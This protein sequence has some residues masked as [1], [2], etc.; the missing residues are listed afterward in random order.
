MVLFDNS[1]AFKEVSEETKAL[2]RSTEGLARLKRRDPAMYGDHHKCNK[3]AGPA[4]YIEK[5]THWCKYCLDTEN[6]PHLT[7]MSQEE[8]DILRDRNI[9]NIKTGNI[10]NVGNYAETKVGF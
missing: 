3:C 7:G 9:A 5:N 8:R 6:Y 1:T 10:V 4:K 2:V